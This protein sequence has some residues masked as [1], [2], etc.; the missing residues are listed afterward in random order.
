M[1]DATAQDMEAQ[2]AYWRD[3]KFAALILVAVSLACR[4]HPE[5]MRTALAQV[6]DLNEANDMAKRAITIATEAQEQAFQSVRELEILKA[7]VYRTLDEMERSTDGLNRR[8]D[9]A[10]KKVTEV[11][12][13]LPK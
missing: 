4:S 2:L 8:L 7:E 3:S 9:R 1:K 12:K 13:R 6:F 5:E 10:A 11:E